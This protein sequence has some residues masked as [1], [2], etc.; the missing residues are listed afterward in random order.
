MAAAA[1]AVAAIPDVRQLLLEVQRRAAAQ[2]CVMDGRDIGTVVLPHAQAKFFLTAS[3]RERARRRWA[4][5]QQ[6]GQDVDL[7]Q[8]C[9][10]LKMRDERD[11]A[12]KH[13]PLRPAADA[14][15]IDSTTMRV[16]QVIDRMLTILARRGLI[17]EA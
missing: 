10:E 17:R 15:V 3:R 2:G 12:R 5:L 14:I 1:S 6:A 7:D 9:A 13:A 4:Q 16:D 8:V 11:A